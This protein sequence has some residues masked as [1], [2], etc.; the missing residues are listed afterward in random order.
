MHCER[1]GKQCH[2]SKGKAEAHLRS[3]RGKSDYVGRVYH[4]ERCGFWHVGREKK[5][6]RENRYRR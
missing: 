1:T 6:T 3:L 4:C 5:G 2:Q